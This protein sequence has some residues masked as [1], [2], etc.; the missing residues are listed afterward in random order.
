VR[1]VTSSTGVLIAGAGP[2]GLMMACQL[3]LRGTPFRII[4]KNDRHITGSGALIIHARTLEYFEQLGI[5][6]KAIE[7]GILA[8]KINIVFH[9]KKYFNLPI[10]KMGKDITRYPGLLLLEQSKTEQLL[11]SVLEAYGHE[12]ERKTELLEF[13]NYT[14]GCTNIVKLPD[15]KQTVIKSQYLVAADGAHSMIREKLRIP[16]AGNTY[17]MSLFCYDGKPEFDVPPNEICFTFT[18]HGSTGLFPLQ[19]DRWRIDGTIPADLRQKEEIVFGDIADRFAQ[20]NH[21]RIKLVTPEWFSVFHSHQQYAGAFGYGRCFMIGDAAHVFSPIG[22]QG[23]NTGLQDACNLA[24]KLSMVLKGLL[25]EGILDTYHEERQ[26]IAKK[27]ATSTDRIFLLITKNH[28]FSK[29]IRLG[30]LPWM[31]DKTLPL[32]E[33]KKVFSDYLFKGISEPAVNYRKSPLSAAA[34]F[35][36]FPSSAP[37]PGDRLPNLEFRIAGR[38]IT[39]QGVSDFKRFHAF[40]FS[41]EYFPD[42]FLEYLTSAEHLISHE[43]IAFDSGTAVAYH[44]FGIRAAGCYLVRPDMYIAFRS[45]NLY[46]NQIR[47]YLKRYM[48]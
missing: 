15:G 39:A 32:I 17:D 16:F 42:E 48:L 30:I 21:L 3:A 22:A 14:E 19:G 36:Y 43:F 45:A 40:V 1:K 47:G 11:I 24:W 27:I 8:R 28:S 35:G 20:K 31:L 2:P 10:D 18:D 12:V 13:T 4:D 5:A 25:N 29:K 9:G 37:K 41:K 46:V 34:S 23:M 44:L 6:R 7:Q 38:K 33:K 26:P